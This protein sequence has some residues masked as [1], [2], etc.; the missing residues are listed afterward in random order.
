MKLIIYTDGASR[1]NPGN[2]AYGFFIANEKGRVLFEKGEYI[3]TS[4]NNFAEYTAVLRSLE[5][6]KDYFKNNLEIDFYMDSK[7]VA[8]QLSGRYKIKS[9]NLKPLI[10]K[11]KKLESE[12]K[13][14]TYS[15]IR[16][17]LNK[18]A[19]KLANLALDCR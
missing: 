17:E 16:R 8:E 15:H 3:G 18:K 9:L 19:D 13:K 2:A 6:V 4:T 1:G 14:I 5:Y 10:Y 7:L 11:I 12:F